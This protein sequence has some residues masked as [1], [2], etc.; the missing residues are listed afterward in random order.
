L[1]ADGEARWIVNA[2]T[3][4]RR[5][6]TQADWLRATHLIDALQ[7]IGV[8]WRMI[9]SDALRETPEMKVAYWISI[10]THFSKHVQD[11]AENPTQSRWLLE[12]LGAVFGGV[13][14]VR[15][16]KPFSFL[17]CP[18]S[19]LVIDGTYTDAYLETLGWEIPV[20]VMPMPMMGLTGPARLIATT[21][22]GNCEV[23][24]MLC[25]IQAAAPGTP[26]IYAPVLAVIDPKT[27]RYSG[28]EIENALLSVAATQMGR[29]YELPVE[30]STGG[31]HAD[32]PGIEAGFERALNWCAPAL[33]WPD[34][35][36]GPGLFD[37][38][39]ILCF[40]QLLLDVE[41]FRYCRR[42]HQG[43]DTNQK[44]WLE[45]VIAMVGPGGDFLA[46]PSTRQAVRSGEWYFSRLRRNHAIRRAEPAGQLNILEEARNSIQEILEEWT[47]LP[48]EAEI[49]QELG[50]IEERARLHLEV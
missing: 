14:T 12:V 29:Y 13:E 37:G 40:E 34:I 47:L 2:W 50:R 11:A 7:D 26:F 9:G 45:E 28:G 22:L 33:A 18:V 41:I 20:A 39:T 24:A 16:I 43:I 6:A 36:V 42:L 3:G 5:P 30:A 1:L 27:G 44:N 25:L 23:L 15:H 31:T 38:S 49:E 10:F 17:L 4:E 48:I 35:L 46:H 21:L 19:P 8:Y 32:L